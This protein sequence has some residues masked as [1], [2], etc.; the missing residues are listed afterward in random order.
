MRFPLLLIFSCLALCYIKMKAQEPEPPSFNSNLSTEEKPWTHLS[1]QDDP[2]HFQFAIVTDRTGGHREGVF[3]DAVKKL[4]MLQPEFVISVGDLIEGNSGED[5]LGLEKEWQEFNSIIEPLSMPFFYLPGNHDI[6]NDVMRQD[7]NKRYGSPYYSFRYKDVLFLCLFTNEEQGET[8]GQDQLEYFEQTLEEH[9]DVR[10]T[11]VFMHHPLWVYPFMSNF[12]KIEEMLSDRSYSVFAG[13]QHTYRQFERKGTQYTILATTGG[14]SG[15][16][17]NSFGQFDHISWITMTDEGPIMANVRLDGI[18]PPDVATT[19]SVMLSR[20]L[21][22]STAFSSDMLVLPGENFTRGMAY[23]SFQNPSDH[24]LHIEASFFHH[25]H[26]DV[27]PI[28]LD[29]IIPANSEKIIPVE[30]TA[31]QP[32]EWEEMMQMELDWEMGYE[33]IDY[34]DLRLKGTY[35]FPVEAAAYDVI[36]TEKGVLIDP[37]TLSFQNELPHTQIRY[38]LDGSDPDLTSSVYTTPLNISDPTKVKAR[39]VTDDGMMSVV[40][41]CLIEAIEPGK[42]LMA[43]YYEYDPSGSSWQVLPDFSRLSPTTMAVADDFELDDIARRAYFYG[44]VYKGNISLSKSG[45]YTFFTRSDDGSKLFIDGK[46]VVDNDLRHGLREESGQIALSKGT[47]TIEI[48]YFQDRAGKGLE[49]SYEL[50]G[51]AR[52][53]LSIENCSYDAQTL[54]ETVLATQT[55]K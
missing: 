2:N 47:H 1:F 8:I 44:I 30:L 11:L 36:P 49:V 46:E 48:H 6:H 41:S 35:A 23:L 34:E 33:L 55:Q 21:V 7:W 45:T 17:G 37:F 19:E 22:Q 40:D 38:T 9:Q 20:E 52:L 54:T 25:H 39:I 26:V 53:P 14:G 31:D 3:A 4:N 10:W 28:K 13:H 51:N 15:L 27:S 43:Y 42:G 18:L 50:E 5:T 12:D 29:E 24:P 32:F 16:R